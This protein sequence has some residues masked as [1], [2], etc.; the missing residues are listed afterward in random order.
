MIE[1]NSQL[2]REKEEKI[3]TGWMPDNKRMKRLNPKGGV[4]DLLF[5]KQLNEDGFNMVVSED[6]L[7]RFDNLSK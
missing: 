7:H 5:L 2:I 6:H 1:R 4:K 3:A